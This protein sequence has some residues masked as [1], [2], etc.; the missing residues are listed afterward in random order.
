MEDQRVPESVG[1]SQLLWQVQLLD[2]CCDGG[3][4]CSDTALAMESCTEPGASAPWH[5]GACAQGGADT[6]PLDLKRF[7]IRGVS[8]SV[9]SIRCSKVY[10]THLRMNLGTQPISAESVPQPHKSNIPTRT[11]RVVFTSAKDAVSH[12]GAGRIPWR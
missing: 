3:P 5:P 9:Y 7:E 12:D 4:R 11:G 8:P 2:H 1:Q 6:R 10:K